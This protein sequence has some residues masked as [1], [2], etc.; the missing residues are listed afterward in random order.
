MF[1]LRIR[2]D[3]RGIDPKVLI[4]GGRLG[5]WG[6]RGIRE[7]ADRIGAH[8]DLWSE[9]ESGTE[10]QLLVPATV[11]YETARDSLRSKMFRKLNRARA[12]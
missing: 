4:E 12:S 7:R 11:A 3:G 8:L 5:H 1:R 6:L 9:P 10:V 2:N